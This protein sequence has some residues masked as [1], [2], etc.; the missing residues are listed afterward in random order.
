MMELVVKEYDYID[1][2]TLV[3][4]PAE[5]VAEQG[6][7]DNHEVST[8]EK[9]GA[10]RW[11]G[12]FKHRD[13]LLNLLLSSRGAIDFGG[14]AGPIGYGAT[15]VDMFAPAKAF[16]D[17]AGP[18]NL[19]FSSHTFEHVP[20]LGALLGA[21]Y[22]KLARPGHLVVF[23]PSW[24][25]EHLRAENWPHHCHTFCLSTDRTRGVHPDWIPLDKVLS[26]GFEV[27]LAEHTEDGCILAIARTRD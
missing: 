25:L 22:Y 23:V 19:I 6:L 26:T 12:I 18:C 8:R 17:L 21:I 3:V 7:V 16:W 10:W 20:D 2:A 9:V 5:Y 11:P 24:R 27:E 4:N 13:R 15:V 1:P 14:A